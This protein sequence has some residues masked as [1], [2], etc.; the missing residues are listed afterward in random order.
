V[1]IFHQLK[2]DLTAHSIAEEET[3]YSRFQ[4]LSDMH[5]LTNDARQEHE[6]IRTLLDEISDVM[7]DRE[8]FLDKIDDLQQMVKNHVYVEENQVFPLIKKNSSEEVL[9]QMSQ[10]FIEAKKRIQENMGM[11]EIIASA[12]NEDSPVVAAFQSGS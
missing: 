8:Q 1:G 12:A 11:D 7:D 2:A 6:D 9:V 5:R 3:V 4:N 10:D